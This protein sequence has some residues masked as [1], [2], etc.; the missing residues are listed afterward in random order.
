MTGP[1]GRTGR[2]GTDGIPGKPGLSVYNYTKNG[3]PTSDF[4]VAPTIL[5]QSDLKNITV[6]EGDNLRLRCVAT[7][8]PRPTIVWQKLDTTTIPLGSWRGNFH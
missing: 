5:G 4:L 1:R 6:K 8:S 2:G 3:I 7:G